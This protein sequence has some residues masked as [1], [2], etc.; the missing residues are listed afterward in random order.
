MIRPV[1]HRSR[2]TWPLSR[3][4]GRTMAMKVR[5]EPEAPMPA[6][7]V[8]PGYDWLLVLEGRVLLW[9]GERHIEVEKGRQPSSRREHHTR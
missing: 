3:V 2:T 7:R 1:Q 4:N 6:Q 5:L 8:H 9:L